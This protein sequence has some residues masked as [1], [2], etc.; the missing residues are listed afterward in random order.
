VEGALAS[1]EEPKLNVKGV[2]SGGGEDESSGAGAAG[3]EL[4]EK[5]KGSEESPLSLFQ[6][7]AR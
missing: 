3:K 1:A 4:K 5:E 7:T 2:E 6:R